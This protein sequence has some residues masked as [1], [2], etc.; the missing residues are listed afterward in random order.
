MAVFGNPSDTG[1]PNG[2]GLVDQSQA[3]PGGVA[4]PP[5]LPLNDPP[6]ASPPAPTIPPLLSAVV[7]TL[8]PNE[9]PPKPPLAPALPPML[10]A[11]VPPVLVGVPIVPP[12][13][14]GFELPLVAPFVP[15]PAIPP[16]PPEETAEVT[17]QPALVAHASRL[18]IVADTQAPARHVWVTPQGTPIQDA[19]I[20][21]GR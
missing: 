6:L 9:L 14:I 11:I 19:S 8:P 20:R 13:T 17:S 10:G 1:A 5:P 18:V 7:P 21:I 2:G 12:L 16:V 3:P 15:P 4:E